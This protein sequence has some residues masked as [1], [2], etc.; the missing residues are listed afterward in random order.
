[1]VLEAQASLEAFHFGAVAITDSDHREVM[2]PTW[3]VP[4]QSQP[5]LHAL[6]HGEPGGFSVP[7]EMPLFHTAL[8]EQSQG[9]KENL[10]NAHI[11]MSHDALTR[12]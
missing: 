9:G 10:Q 11:T 12:H 5:G 3:T 4:L 2:T 8:F 7:S 6:P 1:M